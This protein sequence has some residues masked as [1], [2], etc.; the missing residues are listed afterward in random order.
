MKHFFKELGLTI[1]MVA[2][3]SIVDVICLEYDLAQYFKSNCKYRLKYLCNLVY[4]INQEGMP[5]PTKIQI[6]RMLRN[7]NESN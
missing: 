5:E 7:I 4:R 6:L 1:A 3:N 2:I